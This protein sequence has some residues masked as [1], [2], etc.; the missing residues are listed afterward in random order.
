MK[1]K[2]LS[3]ITLVFIM[4]TFLSIGVCASNTVHYFVALDGDDAND[5]S[6]DAPFA[7]IEGARNAIRS[8]ENYPS[9][10]VVVNIRGGEYPMTSTISFSSQDSGTKEAPVVYRAYNGEE[11]RL[12]GKK[13]LDNSKFTAVTNVTALNKIPESAKGK[14]V[15]MDLSYTGDDLG[16]LVILGSEYGEG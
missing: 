10:G 14:V 9:G 5:G 2:F 1:K 15:Q 7:T 8:L 11:V 6:I 12:S 13:R 3:V 16:K 4:M